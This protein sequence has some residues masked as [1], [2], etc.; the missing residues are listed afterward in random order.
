MGSGI[1]GVGSEGSEGLDL[2]SQPHLRMRNHDMG[3]GSSVFLKDQGP[4]CTV[5]VGS[6]TKICHSFGIEDQKFGY[7]ISREKTL[8][9]FLYI[10]FEVQDVKHQMY[11]G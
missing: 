4:G 1:K 5:F 11:A 6:G 7:G 8:S 10:C 9:L 3:S 2:G